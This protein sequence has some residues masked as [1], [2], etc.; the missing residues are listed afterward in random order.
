MRRP[1]VTYEDVTCAGAPALHYQTRCAP[2][3]A[4]R[5]P[6]GA[7]GQVPCFGP[8]EYPIAGEDLTGLLQKSLDYRIEF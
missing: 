6:Q 8:G 3:I 1:I 7:M 4:H 2:P 5:I